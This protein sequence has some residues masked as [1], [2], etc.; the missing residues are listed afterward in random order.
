MSPDDVMRDILIGDK[1]HLGRGDYSIIFKVD[2]TQ[3]SNIEQTSILEYIHKGRLRLK[4]VLYSGGNP[5]ASISKLDDVV[6][7]G[8]TNN[9]IRVRGG[10]RGR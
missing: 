5:Y 8:I 3:M 2:S 9:Q 1:N 6:R 4:D 7:N 10:C